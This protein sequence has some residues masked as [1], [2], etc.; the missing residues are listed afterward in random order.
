MSAP[1]MG[2]AGVLGPGVVETRFGHENEILV[3]RVGGRKRG[4]VRTN[5]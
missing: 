5:S 1:L 2:A 3:G 4:K